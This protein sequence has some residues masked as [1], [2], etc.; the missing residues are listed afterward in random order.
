MLSPKTPQRAPKFS[1]PSPNT[2]LGG[3]LNH[4]SIM[5]FSTTSK[6]KPVY[7]E[8]AD[9]E[10]FPVPKYRRHV[11]IL[12]YCCILFLAS[13]WVI[14]LVF[15]WH[16]SNST[17]TPYTP[18]PR[19][20]FTRVKKVFQPDERYVGPSA[21]TRHHW[22]DLVAGTYQSHMPANVL[23]NLICVS[24][25]HDAVWIEDPDKWGL[26][27]GIVPPFDHP[28]KLDPPPTNF[29]VISLLHQLHCLVS[30]HYPSLSLSNYL[31]YHKLTHLTPVFLEH[32]QVAI[33][34]GEEGRGSLVRS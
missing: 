12:Q 19:E 33:L 30:Y 25:G 20:V 5:F 14:T 11:S 34:A 26:P 24:S 6:S 28:H 27:G 15:Y 9:D 18:I 29:Y 32:C 1:T 17:K 7:Q 21:E 2:K 13:G 4:P 3:V 8:I 23:P 10:D 22:D 31:S 16:L